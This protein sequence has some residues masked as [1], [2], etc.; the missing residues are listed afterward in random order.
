[1]FDDLFNLGKKRTLTQSVGFYVFYA[2]VFLGGT[3]LLQ[4]LGVE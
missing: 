3:A 1:M 4:L 2:G